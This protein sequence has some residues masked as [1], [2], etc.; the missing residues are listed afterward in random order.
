MRRVWLGLMIR[1]P[2]IKAPRETMLFFRIPSRMEQNLFLFG[3]YERHIIAKIIFTLM[4]E[5]SQWP[6]GQWDTPLPSGHGT[7]LVHSM[8]DGTT[9]SNPPGLLVPGRYKASPY[10][11]KVVGDVNQAQCRRAYSRQLVSFNGGRRT[12][13]APSI[14]SKVNT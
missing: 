14:V 10:L 3:Q 7:G 6:P 2:I 1:W 9:G 12:A 11:D 13:H 5:P 8:W 4:K